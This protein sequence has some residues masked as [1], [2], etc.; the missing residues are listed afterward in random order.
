MALKFIQTQAFQL[1]ASGASA[2]DTTIVL[3]S[4]KMIDGV[5]NIV[6]ADLGDRCY[7]TLEPNNGTQEEAFQFTGVTQNASG[8]AT[9]T[10]VSSVGF[11]SPYTVI[12]GL[13]KSH[14]G[15]V[16]VILSNDAA[17]YGNIKTYIDT[18]VAS[19]ASLADLTT[20]GISKLSVSP[21]TGSNPIAA[22][23][24]NTLSALTLSSANTIVDQSSLS[25]TAASGAVV[26]ARSDTGIIDSTFLNPS[27]V[28]IF[29][30]LGSGTWIKPAN[31]K[32][33]QVTLIGAGGGGGGGGSSN[34]GGGGG[35]GGGEIS[36]MMF[37]ALSLASGV[38]VTVGTH[39]AGGNGTNGGGTGGDTAFGTNLIGK[40]GAGGGSGG[41]SAG[42]G[43]AGGFGSAG[44]AGGTNGT[45][46]ILGGGG[47]ASTTGAGGAGSQ[48]T[49]Y[50]AAGGGGGGGLS[51][52]AGSGGSAFAG[53]PAT[54]IPIPGSG[55]SGGSSGAGGSNAN[56]YGSGGGGAGSTNA[57]TGGNGADGFAQVVTHF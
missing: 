44:G 49:P 19:G 24:N 5:T 51:G 43:G 34:S 15:G 48:A 11:N 35:G 23:A 20:A 7:G 42:A 1:Q 41:G 26:R 31:A 16:T 45:V 10:G 25:T 54:G 39:G 18:V 53:T 14:A 47:G 30:T 37:N 50:F 22:G 17:F 29:T 12:S 38:T 56:A 57:G 8:T 2:A 40:G 28:Q 27:Q 4:F 13:S 3:Q 21:A 46:G 32:T 33:V 36:Q 9:L 6:T 55:G 52:S